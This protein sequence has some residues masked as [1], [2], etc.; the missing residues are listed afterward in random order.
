MNRVRTIALAVLA[1]ALLVAP[2]ARAQEMTPR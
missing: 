1:C 2:P